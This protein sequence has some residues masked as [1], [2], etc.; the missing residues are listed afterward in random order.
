MLTELDPASASVEESGAILPHSA[1]PSMP[2]PGQPLGPPYK[3][4]LSW[5][6][7]WAFMGPGWLMSLAYLDPGNLEAD[8]QQGA[9]TRLRLTW[10]LWWSTVLGLVLQEMAARLGCVTGKD[11]A[12]VAKEKYSPTEARVL[13]VMMEIAVIGA[14]IQVR[15]TR[16]PGA[17]PAM[18]CQP[19][20]PCQP[21]KS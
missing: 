9:Y 1:T 12:T 7:L 18:A 14:D 19:C 16:S 8:L 17:W 10:V 13:Y 11:L 20:Q 5:R 15:P 6:K 2:S 3:F 4:K 21:R